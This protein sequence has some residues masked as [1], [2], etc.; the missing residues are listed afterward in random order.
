MKKDKNWQANRQNCGG[1]SYTL[2]NT[3]ES[4]GEVRATPTSPSP[5][6]ITLAVSVHRGQCWSVG[7]SNE[8]MFLSFFL[9]TDL[10]WSIRDHGNS[11]ENAK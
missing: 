6:R 9:V 1:E 8:K 2:D 5:S 3:V 7:T 11:N 10:I 4:T